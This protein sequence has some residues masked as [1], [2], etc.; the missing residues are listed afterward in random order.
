MLAEPSMDDLIFYGF[1]NESDREK[2]YYSIHPEQVKVS[3][4]NPLGE[5]QMQ[6]AGLQM[7]EILEKMDLGTA[8]DQDLQHLILLKQQLGIK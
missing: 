5:N 2:F 6:K 3:P 7:Q 1:D 4:R 8:T